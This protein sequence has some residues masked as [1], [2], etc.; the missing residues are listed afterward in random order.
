MPYRRVVLKDRIEIQALLTKGLNKTEIAKEL[1]FH[2]ATIGREIRRHVVNRRY[3]AVRAQENA[4]RR[5]QCC[6]RSYKITGRLKGFV[7]SKLKRGWS[8]EQISGRFRRE[9]VRTSVS[10]QSIYRFIKRTG[11]GK[12][13]LRFG[14]KRRGFGRNIKKNHS[15][16]SDW[17]TMITQ[18]PKCVEGRREFGH[19]ERDTFFGSQK[20]GNILVLVERKSR[21][22][23]LR[24]SHT[25]Q[26][27]FMAKL[28]KK[29]LRRTKHPAKTI[30]ND[31]GS[32]FFDIKSLK[33]PVYFC[34]VLKPQQRGSVENLIGLCRQYVKR[35]DALEKISYQQI[36]A[37]QRRINLRPRKTLDYRTPF[38]VFNDLTVALAMDM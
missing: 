14:Y 17:K 6:R 19:W 12:I 36:N 16:N 13:Y 11:H 18:R 4:K 2:K 3:E 15:R 24:K 33:V 20:K 9:N 1:G 37:L 5:F 22:A 25:L 31:N 27:K 10:H 21:Y 28:T 26:S 35:K 29:A 7:K 8:P 34:E 30:T 38:E 32:E 23:V